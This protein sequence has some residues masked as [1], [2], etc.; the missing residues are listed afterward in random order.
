MN[1]AAMILANQARWVA[2]HMDAHR[3]ASF[4]RTARRLET[5]KAR[6]E[7][8]AKRVWSRPDLWFLIAIILEREGS[9]QVDR[10]LGNGQ[11]LNQVTTSVPIGRGPFFGPD[12]FE[13]GCLDALIDCPPHA[14]LWSDWSVGGIL[15]LL[16]SYNG[17]GYAMRGKPS[18]YIWSGTDQYIKGKYKDD[19]IYDPDM[20]DQQEGCAPI[21]ARMI[22]LDP[23][24]QIKGATVT[25]PAADPVAQGPPKAPPPAGFWA[26]VWQLLVALSRQDK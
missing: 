14:A 1:T 21:L 24:I 18:P 12:A 22:A 26:V 3:I 8:I 15:T 25:R 19:H 7:P 2:M 5:F 23:S 4:D 17:F 20:V 13:R 11:P 16:E 6:F 10:Y 9:G